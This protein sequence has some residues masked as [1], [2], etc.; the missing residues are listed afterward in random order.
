[1]SEPVK[2]E[3]VKSGDERVSVTHPAAETSS[4]H[5]RN[6]FAPPV[7][8]QSKA[9]AAT[10]PYPNIVPSNNLRLPD[11][12]TIKHG[13]APLL[14]RFILQADKTVRDSGLRLRLRT[15]FEELAYANEHY[16]ERGTWYPLVDAFN[17]RRTELTPENAF[18]VSGEND[19]GEIVVTWA[20]RIYNW[21]GT[22]LAE[23]ARTV[24]Y[25]QDLDQP[26]VVTAEAAKLISGVVVFAGASW[27][28]PDFRGKHLSHLFPR[29]GKAYACSRWP[30][31]WAI[32]YI[33][34]ANAEKGLATSYGQ[35]NLS[36]S[37]FYPGSPRGEQ[38]VVYTP[39]EQ[40]YADL[41][42]FLAGERSGSPP[43]DTERGPLS[44]VREHIVT[45]ISSVGVLHGN[46]SRS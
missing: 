6:G 10:A 19:A 18:W 14:A 7:T 12:L 42:K 33:G 46:I 37:V 28:R 31:D 25:G 23:Q 34:R 35:Q 4:L 39:V 22:N 30:I 32:G 11:A 1:M 3:S 36:Y 15:D 41:A 40:V 38:V 21:T 5:L 8:A 29:V 20:A 17:P 2:S 9:T 45:N 43:A 27:V 26:C 13:P 16:A 24:W 44:K